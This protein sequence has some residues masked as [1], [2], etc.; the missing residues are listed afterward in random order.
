[1]HEYIASGFIK[2]AQAKGFSTE[3]ALDL[4]IK[5]A[6]EID[7]RRDPD[8]YIPRNIAGWA[9]DYLS[10]TFGPYR[11]GKAETLARALGKEPGFTTKYPLTSRELGGLL[12]AGTG[13]GV[14]AGLSALVSLIMGRDAIENQMPWSSWGG[15]ALGGLAGGMLPT[16]LRRKEMQENLKEY[17]EG[18]KLHPEI[19]ERR[20]DFS[21]WLL[22]FG[23]PHH[24]GQ[25]VGYEKLMNPDG[26]APSEDNDFISNAITP[27]GG[28]ITGTGLGVYQGLRGNEIIDQALDK[29]KH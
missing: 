15:A 7:K 1:M 11:A 12:G 10:P 5:V 24:K 9:G 19:P 16:Y 14:G 2:A 8:Q 21:N 26:T 23:G 6:K 13:A 22:P 18:A 4:C 29:R 25:A 20:S 28:L 3:A 27:L 17:A